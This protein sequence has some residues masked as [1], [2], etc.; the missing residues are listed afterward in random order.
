MGH[1]H[2]L[3]EGRHD[4]AVVD[5]DADRDPVGPH[6]DVATGGAQALEDAELLEGVVALVAEH[7]AAR[8]V[9]AGGRALQH[10]RVVAAGAQQA[11]E[12]ET[13]HP[14]PDD[15]R[16]DHAVGGSGTRRRATQVGRRLDPSAV[17]SP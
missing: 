3:G 6:A 5:G 1:G 17:S 16:A 10:H 12:R 15:D 7:E 9:D 2:P 13:D 14:A 8:A 11:G 4:D